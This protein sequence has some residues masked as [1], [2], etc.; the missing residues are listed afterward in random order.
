MYRDLAEREAKIRRLV[1]ANII[2]IFIRSI[3]GEVDGSIVE[4]ND[5]FLRMVGYDRED[6]ISGRIR[7]AEL[8]P[9]EWR[10]VD[11]RAVAELK[12]TGILPAYEKEYFRKDGS[13]VPVLVGAASLENGHGVAFVVDLTERRRAE[14]EARESERRHRETQAQL[15]HVE[16][17]CNDGAAHGLDRP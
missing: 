15:A 3:T 16:P 6:L 4:A 10:D 8:T 2:G 9:P 14:A 11:A 5:A 13:R 1:D 7:W 17:R 12:T